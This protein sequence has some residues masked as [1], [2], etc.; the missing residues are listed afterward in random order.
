[1]TREG[2]ILPRLSVLAC[3]A[4]LSSACHDATTAPNWP[5]QV[6]LRLV[7]TT[8]EAVFIRAEGDES[9]SPGIANLAPNDSACTTVNAFADSVP[10]EVHSWT[11]WDSIYGTSWVYPL[12]NT[13]WH[14]TV[15]PSGVTMTSTQTGCSLSSGH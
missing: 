11:N 7:N 6:Q 3:L 1:M 4:A 5:V 13:S 15:N 8:T 10:V 14:A 12:R 2:A 9:L